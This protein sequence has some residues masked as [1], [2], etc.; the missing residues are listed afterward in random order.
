MN[1]N[2]A[3]YYVIGGVVVLVIIGAIVYAVMSKPADQHNYG[4]GDMGLPAVAP[5]VQPVPESV[6][7][8]SAS[9]SP[10]TSG[11]IG[12]WVSAVS[13]KGIQATGQLITSNSTS[14]ITLY[15][16]VTIVI[17][18]INGNVA[19]GQLTYTNLCYTSVT[20]FTGSSAAPIAKPAT[21]LANITKPIKLQISGN[22]VSFNGTTETGGKESFSGTYSD[23]SVSGSFTRSSSYGDL[24]G[25]LNVVHKGN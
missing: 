14:K 1:K 11:L 5:S 25:T 16:D 12:K 3:K 6:Q 23:N 22:S 7:T 2:L 21:C 18:G 19:T 10:S 4:I 17:D 9:S 8:S 13:G 24:K 20:T 15:G